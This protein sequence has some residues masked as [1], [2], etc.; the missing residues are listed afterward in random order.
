MYT[1]KVL[2]LLVILYCDAARAP[3]PPPPIYAEYQGWDVPSASE[4]EAEDAPVARAEDIPV[5]LAED[6][7]GWGWPS[8]SEGEFQESNSENSYQE[9]YPNS[10]DEVQ[11]QA[12]P[13]KPDEYF[14]TPAIF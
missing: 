2:V 8:R 5:S 12:K 14:G 13:Q 7:P 1:A 3:P 9:D 6:A 4:S 10:E 11:V